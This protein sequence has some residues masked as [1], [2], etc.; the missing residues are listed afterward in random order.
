MGLP[1]TL[2]A[3]TAPSPTLL[4]GLAIDLS[5]INRT[6]TNTAARGSPFNLGG[7]NTSARGSL[8]PSTQVNNPPKFIINTFIN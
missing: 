6:L 1:S 8:S 3:S 5:G 4:Q 7:T 2:A